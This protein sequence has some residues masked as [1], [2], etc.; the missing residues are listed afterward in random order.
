MHLQARV[1]A[2]RLQYSSILNY[3]TQFYF[4]ATGDWRGIELRSLYLGLAGH[5]LM[6][7]LAWQDNARVEQRALD[8]AA[9]ANDITIS[10]P[11]SRGG[12]YAQ[13]EWRIGDTLTATLGLRVDHNSATGSQTS[14]RVALIWQAA[15]VTTLKALYGRAHRAPNAYERDYSDGLVLVANPSLRGESIDTVELVAD[16]R[17][18]SDMQLHAAVY[19]WI[20]HNLIALGI[21]PVS[22][23]P[24][25]RS[26]GDVKATGAEF[27]ADKS[28]AAGGRL[29]GSI[30]LQQV[31][32]DAGSR[33]LNSPRLLAKLNFSAPLPVAGVRIAYDLQYDSSRL[34]LAGSQTGGYGVSNLRLSSHKQAKG[35]E[36]GMSLR[37]LF[38]KR[39]AHP[40]SDTNWQNVFQ[41]DGRSLAFDAQFRF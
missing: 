35:L 25:Y 15:P 26:S 13:D 32:N 23:F 14:P 7:G 19:R 41:Q 31:R 2:G 28:W 40:G 12:I 4:P 18:A 22:G 8:L 10:S 27:A 3:G 17:L 29:R 30:A 20:M 6:M 21:D 11:G 16:H 9:P 36:V 38:D 37:N 34:T 24:Q 5:K 33:L 1:F 39:Y